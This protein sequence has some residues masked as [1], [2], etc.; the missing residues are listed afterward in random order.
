[1]RENRE[2]C[3]GVAGIARKVATFTP[4]VEGGLGGPPFRRSDI[5]PCLAQKWG[6]LPFK[7]AIF[8]TGA[9]VGRFGGSPIQRCDIHPW[10]REWGFGGAPHSK[11]RHPPL[12]LEWGGLGGPPHAR[13]RH[14]PHRV[15]S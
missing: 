5:H 9:E 3:F 8:T 2:K 12:A 6:V 7:D 14:P 11:M 15:V 1:M 4:G 13:L 10:R